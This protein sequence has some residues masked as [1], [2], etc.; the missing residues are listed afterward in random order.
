METDAE[1]SEDRVRVELDD[2]CFNSIFEQLSIE[3]LVVVNQCSKRL[4]KIA[5]GVIE[6]RMPTEEVVVFR[7]PSLT[8][9]KFSDKI[10][11][12]FAVNL[13]IHILEE[14]NRLC[15]NLAALEVGEHTVVDM[16]L[17]KSP[18]LA[19][20]FAKLSK[21]KIG[22]ESRD[23]EYFPYVEKTLFRCQKLKKL[24]L[25]WEYPYFLSTKFPSLRELELLYRAGEV[26]QIDMLSQFFQNHRELETVDLYVSGIDVSCVLDLKRLVSLQINARLENIEAF[27][28]GLSEISTLRHFEMGT[29]ISHLPPFDRLK[30]LTSLKITNFNSQFDV[31]DKIGLMVILDMPNLTEF[32]YNTSAEPRIDLCDI[33]FV[34]EKCPSLKGLKIGRFLEIVC[35]VTYVN[36]LYQ[37]F[38][39]ACQKD[40]IIFIIKPI[41]IKKNQLE[42]YSD[43]L[44]AVRSAYN[45]CKR[46]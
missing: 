35:N 9:N 26:P 30:Q 41:H 17:F 46:I 24:S 43:I 21:L 37:H 23:D 38:R 11:K 13:N 25:Y 34:V 45:G 39:L 2:D 20:I 44:N 40:N 19:E 36:E 8:L 16:D 3:D 5:D 4:K 29:H 18:L 12:I 31:M 28:F 33:A 10:T 42:T 6:R 22:I 14:I 27:I 15:N 32:C 1:E 7:T